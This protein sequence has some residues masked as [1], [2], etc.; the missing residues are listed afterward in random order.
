VIRAEEKERSFT[1]EFEQ[2]A[3]RPCEVGDRSIAQVAKDPDL[4]ALRDRVKR[5]EI[6]AGTG[7]S[8]R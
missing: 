5:A 8:A 2:G 7:R 6:D 3:V 1:A 4:T